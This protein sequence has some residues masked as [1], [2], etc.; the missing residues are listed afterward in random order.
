MKKAHDQ[1]NR[2]SRTCQTSPMLR[3]AAQGAII[4]LLLFLVACGAATEGARP[5]VGA[6]APDLSLRD[7]SGKTVNLSDYRG[8][9]VLLNFWATWCPPCREEMPSMEVLHRRLEK[10][11]FVL[12]A[13]SVDQGGEQQVREFAEQLGLTFPVLLDPARESVRAY[14]ANAIPESVLID[15]RGVIV[16]RVLGSKDWASEESLRIVRKALRS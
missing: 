5:N 2:T 16:Q 9:A 11:G 15:R 8:Q 13:V 12:L 3:G 10:D 14:R 1:T 4:G 7:L 6:P